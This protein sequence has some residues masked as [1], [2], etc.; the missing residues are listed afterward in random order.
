MPS[1]SPV[2]P[3]AELAPRPRARLVDRVTLHGAPVDFREL[4]LRAV[5]SGTRT[6]L[7]DLDR[8]VHLG[9]NM[10][11]LLGFEIV[12]HHGYG[13]EHLDALEARRGAGRFVIDPSRPRALARYLAI[14]ARMWAMPGLYYFVWGKL[15]YAIDLL[16]RA[17]FRALGPEPVREAQRVPQTALM[18]HMAELPLATLRDLSAC[19]LRRHEGDQ[20]ILREDVAWLRRRLPGL[21]V[22]LTS[23]SPQPM[24][25]VAAEELGVDEVVYSTIEEH[26]GFLS[27]P[28]WR[29]RMF[30][31]AREP[32][33]VSPPSALKLNVSHAKIDEIRRRFPDALAEPERAVGLTDT[34]YGEDH[35]WADHLGTVVDVNSTAPFPPIVRASSPLREVHSAGLL[36]RAERAARDAGSSWLDPRRGRASADGPVTLDE[37]ALAFA[38]GPALAEVEA[39]LARADAAARATAARRGAVEAALAEARAGVEAAAHAY[40]AAQAPDRRAALARL[41]ERDRDERRARRALAAAS[42]PLSEVA[43]D[44]AVTLQRARRTV[45]AVALAARGDEQAALAPLAPR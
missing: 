8:T 3:S 16:R 36:T 39:L 6:L 35:A 1:A 11:E 10:G 27:A 2:S 13:A 17:S 21:R 29:S 32:R 33:R 40:N 22:L 42:R 7:L 4:C 24:L 30:L 34:G 12:A 18:H 37:A 19:V 26:E 44:L 14:G 20:V 38:L 15:A 31:P 41:E 5:P 25:E 43:H 23:A 45:D 9:R 28:S